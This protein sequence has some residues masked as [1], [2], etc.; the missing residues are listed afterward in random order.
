MHS[1]L[2]DAPERGPVALATSPARLVGEVLLAL[3]YVVR[4]VPPLVQDLRMLVGELTRAA[5]ED[6]ELTAL[7]AETARLAH[8][9]AIDLE[10]APA[11]ATPLH[12]GAAASARD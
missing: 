5:S 8:A 1:S 6:G 3:P 7:L 4:Q 2:P 9:K 10:P 11:G 12:R